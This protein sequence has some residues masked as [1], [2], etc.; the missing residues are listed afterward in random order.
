MGTGILI[1]QRFL[2]GSIVIVNRTIAALVWHTNGLHT[3]RFA[4]LHELAS[5]LCSTPDSASL[6]LGMSHFKHFV[7]VRATKT[8]RELGNLLI[9]APTRGGK[10]LRA[11]TQLLTW[12]QS[13]V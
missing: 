6:L 10:G 1:I 5:L 2:M 11:I 12:G 7:L 8:R 3:A 9:V 4:H 13:V